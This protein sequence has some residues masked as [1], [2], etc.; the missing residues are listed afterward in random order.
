M[1]VEIA[2]RRGEF[3]GIYLGTAHFEPMGEDEDFHVA[4]ATGNPS[5]IRL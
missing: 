5:E 3:D 2:E 1:T 4:L